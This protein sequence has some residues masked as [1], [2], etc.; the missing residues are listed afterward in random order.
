MKHFIRRIA[1]LTHKSFAPRDGSI[2]LEY[3]LCEAT[4]CMKRS[5]SVGLLLNEVLINA[6]KHA[7]KGRSSGTINIESRRTGHEITLCISDD[8]VGLPGDP[9]TMNTNSLGMKLI[10]KLAKQLSADLDIMSNEYG[11]TYTLNFQMEQKEEKE[12]NV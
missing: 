6:Y 10:R 11:T 4:L 2:A 9:K 5:I 8:G 12:V 7:F 3:S 1:D